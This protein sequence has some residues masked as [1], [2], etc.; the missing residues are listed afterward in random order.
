MP[1]S[2]AAITRAVDRLREEGDGSYRRHQIRVAEDG[3]HFEVALAH[4]VAEY[5]N[6]VKGIPGRRF[7]RETEVWTIPASPAALPGVLRIAD[8][9]YVGYDAAFVQAVRSLAEDAVAEA[10]E[11]EKRIEASQAAS[12]ELEVEGLGGELRPFQRAGV[13][14]AM[15]TRRT[16]IADQMGLGKTIQALA[17]V[18]AAGAFPALV[19]CPASLKLNWRREAE[20]WL[21]GR[22]VEVV[23]GKSG[24]ADAD[25]VIVNYDILAKHAAALGSRGFQAII[26]DESHYAKNHK[27][28]RTKLCTEL[29]K[30]V[31]V[32]L[33]LSGTPLTNRPQELLSQLKILGRLEEMGGFWGF[34]NRY[35]AAERTRFGLDLSG[36]SHLD[37]LNTKLRATCYVRRT[38]DEV[39]KELPAKQ[40]AVVP[41]EIDNAAEYRKAERDVVRFL[42]EA[43]ANNKRR[44]AEAVKEYEREHGGKPDAGTRERLVSRVRASA[45]ANA[46]RAEQL[47]RI[48][49]LKS[50]AARGKLEEASRWVEDFLESGEKL[51]VFGWH[52]EIVDALA[53]R[54][55]APSITGDTSGEA[56]QA[57]VDAFQEDPEVRLLVCNIKAGGVGITL[58]AASNVAFLEQGWTPAEHEQAEDRTHRIGQTDSVT[59]WYLLAEDT[60]DSEIHELVEAKR[61]VVDAATEGSGEAA[62]AGV[63]SELTDKLKAKAKGREE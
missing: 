33:L 48:E 41:V 47:V 29:A 62:G 53:E 20:R 23:D 46:E 24:D 28:K 49:A 35:C 52:R 6:E 42:G 50:T 38:K 27:A 13:A 56:R 9:G 51:V 4:Y 14:Y 18:Q 15:R 2:Q 5:V 57:A 11:K 63:L 55:E 43:A 39:L 16:F 45:E 59:A 36:A 30:E 40:R 3:R 10:A 22:S 7:D 26:L 21:P 8:S 37:E 12:A 60:I 25:V 1:S 31:P 58:T 61:K 54:F 17:T 34:A 19:I 32:R 44:I